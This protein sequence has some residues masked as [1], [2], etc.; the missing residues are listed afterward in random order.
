MSHQFTSYVGNRAAQV[1]CAICKGGVERVEFDQQSD[2]LIVYCHGQREVL[3]PVE[4][5]GRVAVQVVAFEPKE[6]P[7]IPD[8]VGGASTG[9]ACSCGTKGCRV[10]ARK[11]G[12]PRYGEG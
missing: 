3:H 6:D 11:P 7:L 5:R 12:C 2:R 8:G 9:G 1:R 4:V 10:D